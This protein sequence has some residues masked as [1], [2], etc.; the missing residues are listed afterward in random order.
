MYFE[1]E[2]DITSFAQLTQ[3]GVKAGLDEKEVSEWLASDR[4][5]KEVDE[6][7]LEARRRGISGVPNFTVNGKFEVGG[8]QESEV[9]EELFEK[10]AR[11]Q[12]TTAKA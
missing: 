8:A 10:I 6:D 4:G 12:V 11:A 7:V 9:F 5:G 2:G 3:A 1:N